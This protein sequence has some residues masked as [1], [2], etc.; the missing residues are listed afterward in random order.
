[1]TERYRRRDLGHLMLQVT[2]DDPKVLV[3]PWTSPPIEY[4]LM[5]DTDL[6]EEVCLENEKSSVHYVGK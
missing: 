3:R 4:V 5:A 2:Y 1:L 6:L